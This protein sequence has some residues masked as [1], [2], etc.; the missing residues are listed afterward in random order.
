ME[1][2]AKLNGWLVRLLEPRLIHKLEN[3]E[4]FTR[5]ELWEALNQQEGIYLEKPVFELAYKEIIAYLPRKYAN[6]YPDDNLILD[7]R[8]DPE[9]L[10]EMLRKAN[11]KCRCKRVLWP[12]DEQVT[13]SAFTEVISQLSACASAGNQSDSCTWLANK[14]G[15]TEPAAPFYLIITRVIPC[16]SRRGC[17]GRTA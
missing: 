11:P 16:R 7:Y 1:L 3:R 17:S 4:P 8:I 9:E 5:D 14:K 12:D 15:T 2:F 10:E 6:I 13:F